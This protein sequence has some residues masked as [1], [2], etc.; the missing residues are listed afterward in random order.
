MAITVPEQASTPI[1]FGSAMRPLKV[2]EI[3]QARL[4]AICAP[5]MMQRVIAQCQ[6]LT[7]D[8]SIYREN[9]DILV[10]ALRDDGFSVVQPDGA[11]YLFIKS[12]EKDA[13]AFSEKAKEYELLLVPS[14]SF[15]VPGYVRLSYCVSYETCVNSLPGF[16]KLSEKY[17]L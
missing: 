15:G 12:P 9:R 13:G 6:G 2:S 7:S 10:E 5:S 16:K 11:F 8:V 4:E 3:S 14:D 1:R 17:G